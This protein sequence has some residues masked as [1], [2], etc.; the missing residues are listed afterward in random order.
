MTIYYTKSRQHFEN[1]ERGRVSDFFQK[2]SKNL[3]KN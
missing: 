1:L 2:L 3:D